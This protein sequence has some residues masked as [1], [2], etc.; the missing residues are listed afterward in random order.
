MCVFSHN[1][2]Y[3]QIPNVCLGFFCVIWA[4]ERV[5]QKKWNDTTAIKWNKFKSLFVCTEKKVISSL[6]FLINFEFI[7]TIISVHTVSGFVVAVVGCCGVSFYFSASIINYNLHRWRQYNENFNA[8]CMLTISLSFEW[9]F[10]FRLVILSFFHF[11]YLWIVFG[12]KR[13]KHQND[14]AINVGYFRELVEFL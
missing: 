2:F 9:F 5:K 8:K 7:H 10:D 6:Y 4:R 3:I 14:I 13:L 12:K 1:F 11:N